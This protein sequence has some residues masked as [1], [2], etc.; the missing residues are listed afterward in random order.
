MPVV[1]GNNTGATSV[2]IQAGTAGAGAINI[3][4][5]ANAVPVVV[6]NITGATSVTI[7]SGTGSTT[8]SS[9]GDITASAAGVATLD[10]VGVVELNSSG[11]AI[12]IGNDAVAQ[13]INVGTGGAE[14]R[15]PLV[16]LQAL[17]LLI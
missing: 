12:S 1:I 14:E 11:A 8:M 15:L 3:G 17:Q 16:M 6:G 5:T 7:N 9:T 2:S 10:A 4:T 13:A